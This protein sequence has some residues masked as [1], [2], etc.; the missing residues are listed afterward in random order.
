MWQPGR[1]EGPE[2]RPAGGGT[3]WWTAG[4]PAAEPGTRYHLRQRTAERPLDF[5]VEDERANPVVRVTGALPHPREILVFQDVDG[6][7]LYRTARP[8]RPLVPAVDLR[9]PD[10]FTAAIVHDAMLSP[11][12]DRWRIDVP[13]GDGMVAAG[14]ILQHEYALLRRGRTVATVSKAGVRRRDAYTVT[15]AGGVDV[16]LALAVAVI[17]D[18]MSHHH[19][20]AATPFPG[21]AP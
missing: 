20:A 13:G 6:R 12:R 10:G 14:S 9:R 1:P 17:L 15:V 16:P 2:G 8:S 4:R 18:L 11:V 3:A 21:G 7:E 19:G 5:F